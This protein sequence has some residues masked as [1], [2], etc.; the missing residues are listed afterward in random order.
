MFARYFVEIDVDPA[1]VEASLLV[2]TRKHGFQGLRPTPM[3]VV[4]GLLAAVGFGER[5]GISQGGGG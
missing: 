2:W 4:M 3:S 5:L 1:W